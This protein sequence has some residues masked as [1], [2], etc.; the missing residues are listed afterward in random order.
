MQT[1][2][3]GPNRNGLDRF[4]V[5]DTKKTTQDCVVFFDVVFEEN[6]F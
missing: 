6:L 4:F 3:N 2:Q 5:K 1:R